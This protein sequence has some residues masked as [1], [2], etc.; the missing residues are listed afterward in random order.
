M[1]GKVITGNS[2][3]HCFKYCLEDKIDLSEE[4]KLE[5]SKRDNV[6]HKERAE[7]LYYNNCFGN[8]NELTS[9]FSEVSKLSRRVEKPVFHFT[10]SLAHGENL[11]KNQLIEIAQACTAE[12]KVDKNQYAVVLHKDTHAQHIHIV[13]NRVGYDGKVASNS[14][15]YRQM[16]NLCR[17]LELKHKLKQ[18]LS[19]RVF[20]PK[21]QRLIPRQ[22]VRMDQLK[23]NIRQVLQ[24]V[25]TYEQFEQKMKSLG[26][27]VLKGRG[28]AFIDDKKVKLK[29]S[30]VGYS[31]MTIERLLG[32]KQTH[33]L[34]Q[35]TEE[36]NS[37]EKPKEKQSAVSNRSENA[38]NKTNGKMPANETH[39]PL[40]GTHQNQ[41]LEALLKPEHV[42]APSPFLYKKKKKKKHRHRF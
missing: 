11:S 21:E 40:P 8:V 24:Q 4:Q 39:I 12:F 1:I 20:L 5:L 38:V 26:Y 10:L 34:V 33:K 29:G 13:A 30:E 25:K 2:F 19:P 35:K 18:V 42:D 15:N 22:N 28:I 6:Q 37:K 7:V 14:N 32:Q 36:S 31:L 17:K 27:Q 9:Q 41:L 16:A 23:E 3:Y